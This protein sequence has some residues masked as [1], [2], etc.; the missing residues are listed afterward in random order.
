MITETQKIYILGHVYKKLG[1]TGVKSK[2]S[3]ILAI[4][5]LVK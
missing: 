4:K 2:F 1:D 3:K 5:M